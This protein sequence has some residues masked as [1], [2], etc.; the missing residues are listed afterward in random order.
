MLQQ[1]KSSS[2]F[3]EKR[4]TVATLAELTQTTWDLF[5]RF[6]RDYEM[7]PKAELTYWKIRKWANVSDHQL[8]EEL[9]K[10][11]DEPAYK[12]AVSVFLADKNRSLLYFTSTP[13]K[14]IVFVCFLV[15]FC[16]QN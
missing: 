8:R 5:A 14:P 12:L 13:R 6:V 11:I 9:R 10:L 2:S 4:A 3:K 1:S 15:H 16:G 7:K